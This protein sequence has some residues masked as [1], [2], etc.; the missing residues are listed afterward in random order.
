MSVITKLNTVVVGSTAPEEAE[1]S[2]TTDDDHSLW[3][4]KSMPGLPDDGAETIEL[5]ALRYQLV[6][7]APFLMIVS[8]MVTKSLELRFRTYL[9]TS[10]AGLLDIVRL[11]PKEVGL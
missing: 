6:S 3:K 10:E 1:G 7:V 5:T 9:V 2:R 11:V 8:H 4:R